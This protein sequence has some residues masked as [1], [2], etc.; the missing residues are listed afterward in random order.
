MSYRSTAIMNISA[1]AA[2]KPK[3]ITWVSGQGDEDGGHNERDANAIFGNIATK[4]LR[5]K[6]FLYHAWHSDA[7]GEEDE[8]D[9][10]C[11]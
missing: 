5:F 1:N 6:A 11:M 4:L 10:T 2:H 3:V 8:L 7:K 9:D